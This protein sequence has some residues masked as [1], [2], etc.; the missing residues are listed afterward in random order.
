MRHRLVLD[1]LAARVGTAERLLDAGSGQ[2][3]LLEQAAREGAAREYAGFELSRSG[4]EIS[5]R[6]LPQATFVQVDL[7]APPA[8]AAHFAAW[9]TAA[10]CSEVI[11][12]VDD[13][14]AFLVALRS[15]LAHGAPLILT[16][17]GGPMSA[18]DR[19]IGHRRHYTVDLVREVLEAAGFRVEWVRRAGFPFF[20]LYRLM[21]VLRGASLIED[22]DVRGLDSSPSPAARLAMRAFSLLLPLSARNSP[23]GWQLVAVATNP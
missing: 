21:I 3:D 23:F 7:F 18:F 22:V 9:A 11:E 6:K 8:D 10:F 17:P 4:A 20:N 13:P 19:H 1:A 5:R 16:V 14:A 15:Y 12:H 2:G